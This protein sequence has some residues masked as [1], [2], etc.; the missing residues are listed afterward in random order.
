[1][2]RQFI[3]FHQV[4]KVC[5]V[6]ML[7]FRFANF[8]RVYVMVTYVYVTVVKACLATGTALQFRHAPID[9]LK[10]CTS[11]LALMYVLQVQLCPAIT[12]QIEPCAR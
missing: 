9:M 7:A 11:I 2:L 4:T 10:F 12:N 3:Y 5:N 8:D 6:N 1:M